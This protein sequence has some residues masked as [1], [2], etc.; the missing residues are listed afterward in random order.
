MTI[1]FV[2]LENNLNMPSWEYL[3]G[4]LSASLN[5]YTDIM[6]HSNLPPT[7]QI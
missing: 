6:P 3:I 4:L 7:I 1:W 2:S 5:A